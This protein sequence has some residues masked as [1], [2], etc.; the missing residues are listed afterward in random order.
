MS[1][2]KGKEGADGI[3]TFLRIRPSKKPSDYF[4]INELEQSSLSFSLPQG[5]RSE[6]INNSKLRH[7]F[8]FNGI[9]PM[10]AK[11]DD[12]FSKVG[13]AAVQNALDGF[14]STIFAYGQTGSGKTFTITG[15][16]ERYADRG[17]IPR[18][19]SMIFSEFRKR[20]DVQCKIFISYLELYNEQGYD[21]LD[22]T[23]E[24]K[25]LEDMPKVNIL[26]DEHG[27]F[28]IKNLSM[29]PAETEEDALNLLFMGDT[30]R[31]IAETPM[32]MASSRSHCIFTMAMEV[33]G[34]GSDK[35]RRSKLHLVDL[36]GSERVK[37]TNS[38]GSIL[39]EAK[40]IN[41]SLFFLEM[42]VVALHEKATKG[43]AHIPYRNSM[44]TSVLRDSLGG[45]SKT[46]MIATI[47]PEADHTDESLSTCRFAQRVSLIKNRA[48][49]NEDMDPSMVIRRLK[50]EILTLREEIAFLKGEAGEGDVLGPSELDTLK[51]QCREYC[52]D[53]DP[54]SMLNVGT[55]TLTKIKDAFAIM[56][57][58]VLEARAKSNTG[59]SGTGDRATSAQQ[60]EEMTTL[61]QQIKDMKSCLLQRDNEIAI[62]VNMVKKGK[63]A[64]HVSNV[65]SSREGL[66][67]SGDYGAGTSP[68]SS[69]SGSHYDRSGKSSSHNDVAPA[70]EGDDRSVTSATNQYRAPA[71]PE[72]IQRQRLAAREEKVI[73]RHLF[74]VAPPSDAAENKK[75]MDDPSIAFEYFR[76]KC[77]LS[78]AIEE[79]KDLLRE[80][81]GEAKLLG[82]RANQS[83]STITYL[84]SSIESLRRERA[85]A[86][87]SSSQ[88][89]MSSMEAAN[90]MD[91]ETEE[92]ANHRKAIEQEK[93]VYKESF[94]KLRVLKPEIEH[95]RKILEKGRSNL[96]SQ[97]DQWYN[98]LLGRNGKVLGSTAGAGTSM[99]GA[100]SSANTGAGGGAVRGGYTSA[101]NVGNG[102]HMANV[103]NA[104]AP[105]ER[106]AWGTPPQG[107]PRGQAKA[108][109]KSAGGDD[110]NDDI[111]AFQQAKEE[112]LKRRAG[113]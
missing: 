85:M 33:R 8:H 58:C 50:Q 39:T 110:V 100:P 53:H 31:A 76:T 93:V 7:D 40:Y 65:V 84:K 79:N 24:S 41:S 109:S 1:K 48:T 108:E 81:Y 72:E 20:T 62:L 3:Q 22:P 29:N 70:K 67:G 46:I 5:F 107:A 101:G 66:R 19:I 16:P 21:L 32:N 25:A 23:H 43:R 74:G 104:S 35:I 18:A 91:N 98:A 102:S 45:N 73:N 63:T 51:T 106:L 83:R 105:A 54:R 64:S 97:F 99:Y 113:R 82:E 49:I 52:D 44:M 15:G 9:I 55:M 69:S 89:G 47:N 12:V 77:S 61:T 17:I 71:D 88:D 60:S 14:N 56:K 27:N 95:I 2:G 80:K 92:E 10:D 78:P 59:P 103:G 34:N 96:Q 111:R 87:L 26:E 57:N 94:E 90:K 112:L 30:N 28:H 6:Y 75:V 11:Q 13:S 42:V 38:S 86:N 37:K 68:V 36:A 4:K